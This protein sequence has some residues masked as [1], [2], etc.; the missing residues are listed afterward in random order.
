M[1]RTDDVGSTI[2]CREQTESLQDAC[3]WPKLV[4]VVHQQT[5]RGARA[6]NIFPHHVD[7]CSPTLQ[8]GRGK[9]ICAKVQP[10]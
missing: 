1:T 8:T 3:P 4:H 5:S 10:V 7:R 9:Y 2:S 6:A